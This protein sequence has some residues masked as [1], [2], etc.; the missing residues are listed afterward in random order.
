[1]KSRH[2]LVTAAVACAVATGAVDAAAQDTVTI[3]TPPPFDRW[4]V[5]PLCE[6]PGAAPPP[7][8]VPPL[9]ADDAIG[10]Y[11]EEQLRA[12]VA[13]ELDAW[14]AKHAAAWNTKAIRDLARTS[15]AAVLHEDDALRAAQGLGASLVRASLT[16]RLDAA[17]PSDPGCDGAARRDAIY[18]GLGI[19]RAL[20]V[21]AFPEAK[22]S[23]IAACRST[24]ERTVDAVDGTILRALDVGSDL[25]KLLAAGK[26][27]DVETRAAIAAC[28]GV[29]PGDPADGSKVVAALRKASTRG[30]LADHVDVVVAVA[31]EKDVVSTWTEGASSTCGASLQGLATL[32]LQPL[33]TALAGTLARAQLGAIVERLGAD[34]LACAQEACGSAKALLAAV[35]DGLDAKTLRATVADVRARLG[36]TVAGAG[37]F[38]GV[39]DA[40]EAAVVSAATNAS[41]DG[42]ATIDGRAF[43]RETLKEHC[44]DEEGRFSVTC[45]VGKPEPLVLEANG[46][47]PRLESD[48]LRFVGD[49]TLGWKTESF[50]VVGRGALSYFDYASATGATDTTRALG[51]L[52]AWWRSGDDVTALRFELRAT[53]GVDWYDS[54]YLPTGPTTTSG[55]F[56][57]EDSLLARGALLVGL[58]V[59]PSAR[60]FLEVLGGGGAQYESYGYLATDPRDPNVLSDTTAV[61]GRANA[62]LFLRW[63]FWPSVLGLRVRAD[64]STFQLTRDVF[65]VAQ[66]GRPL[67]AGTTSTEVRQLETTSRVF[68]DLDFAKLLGFV[69]SAWAGVDLYRISSSCRDCGDTAVTVPVLGLGIVR[70]AF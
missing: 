24:A 17:L 34:P 61:S 18:E 58:V 33:R 54:T 49:L 25:P 43:V 65:T 30:T 36:L 63:S 60:F 62:R 67:A 42:P 40:L 32:D 68:L 5:R 45:A 27:L 39:L 64:G 16:L 19:T 3:T 15:M 50:G 31:A 2:A 46:G 47:V 48:D 56:H 51:A 53:A 6:E 14:I 10:G 29:K 66:I 7:L 20:A 9:L 26:R 8:A 11:A 4:C 59:Q 38:S 28:E 37:V 44:L 1:M 52:E 41:T 69:P 35:R 12:A 57:D 70:P 23:V 55:Y 21:F 13:R 22:R